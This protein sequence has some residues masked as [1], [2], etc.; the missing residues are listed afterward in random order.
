MAVVVTRVDALTKRLVS[1]I[2]NNNNKIQDQS[3]TP[4]CRQNGYN[5]EEDNDDNAE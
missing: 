5:C 2:N 1:S 3:T 4:Q